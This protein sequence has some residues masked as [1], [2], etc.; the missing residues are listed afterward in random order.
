MLNTK[1]ISIG[2]E[3]YKEFKSFKARLKSSEVKKKNNEKS[4]DKFS[5]KSTITTQKTFKNQQNKE[6]IVY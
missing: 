6:Q 2:S 3:K 5:S 4:V 1:D